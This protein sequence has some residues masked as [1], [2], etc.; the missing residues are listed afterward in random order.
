MLQAVIM[1]TGLSAVHQTTRNF[2]LAAGQRWFMYFSFAFVALCWQMQCTKMNAC[3][4]VK[5][6]C[7]LQ[8]KTDYSDVKVD[9]KL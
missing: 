3:I 2:Q 7:D 9:D 6:H 8:E 1:T 4:P 5:W